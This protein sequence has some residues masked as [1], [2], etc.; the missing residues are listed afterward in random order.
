[1]PMKITVILC[2]YNRAGSLQRALESIALS[3]MPSSV[4]WNVLVVDN[5]STDATRSI[6]QQFSDRYPNRFQYLFEPRQG[7]SFALNSGVEASD[8]DILAFADDDATVEPDW[9]WNLTSA[10]QEGTWSGAGGKIIPTWKEPLPRWLSAEDSHTVGPFVSFDE[11]PVAGQLTRPPY[12]ANMAFRREVFQKY[13]QFRTD[14]GP[15]P[16]NEIRCEDMEF[17]HRLLDG[18]ENLRYEPSAVVYHPVP[19]NRLTKTFMRRWWFWKGY[20]EIVQLGVP[21]ATHWRAGG[22][23]L[24]LFRRIT[25]WG[26][27]WLC[28]PRA[29][30]RF[31]CELDI[32]YISGI[33]H[34]CRRQHRGEVPEMGQ[35][36]AISHKHPD[37]ASET[38]LIG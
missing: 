22:V 32:C 10:L 38:T 16:G 3:R 1:M 33:I 19:E 12:G 20:A 17:T 8:G 36:H 23:P 27:Q 26:L 11:G 7:K 13:G 31:S 2:T 18:G 6:V 5:N 21:P 30:R 29:C 28:S 14:L 34:A 25:R 9:L 4:V 35:Q 37:A 15:R 24:Y